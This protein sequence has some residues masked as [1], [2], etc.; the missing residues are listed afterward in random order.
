[1]VSI[2]FC[3]GIRGCNET[4]GFYCCGAI[5]LASLI[6]DVYSLSSLSVLA[7]CFVHTPLAIAYLLKLL[8]DLDSMIVSAFHFVFFK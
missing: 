3:A 1:M 6:E 8:V 4:Y 2:Y 5:T 7:L